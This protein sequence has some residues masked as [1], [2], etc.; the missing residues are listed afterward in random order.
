MNSQVGQEGN[1]NAEALLTQMSSA[2]IHPAFRPCAVRWGGQRAEILTTESSTL[3]SR[4]KSSK[5]EGRN[6]VS[7]PGWLAAEG[8]K[9]YAE[10]F[11]DKRGGG[12]YSLI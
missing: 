5:G 9:S 1:A 6:G 10:H 8:G 7:V 4:E 3:P 2:G 11:T 12:R